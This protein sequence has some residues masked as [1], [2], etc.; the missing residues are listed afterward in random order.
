[1]LTSRLSYVFY[2]KYRLNLYVLVNSAQKSLKTSQPP[3]PASS[4][5]VSRPVVKYAMIHTH[6]LRARFDSTLC[7]NSLSFYE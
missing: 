2:K 3:V 4:R 7:E 5:T 1:M 6:K